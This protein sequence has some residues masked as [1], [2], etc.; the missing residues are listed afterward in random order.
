MASA[1]HANGSARPG[2][3]VVG[4]AHFCG[5]DRRG[6]APTSGVMHARAAPDPFGLAPDGVGG[7]SATQ[8]PAALLGRRRAV[9]AV[10]L[11]AA[12]PAVAAAPV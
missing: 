12:E 4:C 3:R 7:R 5:D 6:A 10:T 9:Q 2:A 1:P 8:A 11:P